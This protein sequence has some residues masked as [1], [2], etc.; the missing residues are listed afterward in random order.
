MAFAETVGFFDPNVGS[1]NEPAAT[2]MVGGDAVVFRARSGAT[3]DTQYVDP[4]TGELWAPWFDPDARVMETGTG[5]RVARGLPVVASS[6]RIPGTEDSRLW[7]GL[8]PW[9]KGS[10]SDATIHTDATI[11]IAKLALSLIHI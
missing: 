5:E 2:N 9:A 4:D 3:E 7:L 10:G 6:I 1:P 8:N 11:E